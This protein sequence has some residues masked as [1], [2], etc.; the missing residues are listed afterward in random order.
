MLL[1]IMTAYAQTDNAG[2]KPFS[3]YTEYKGLVI[4]SG[5]I[6]NAD[7]G[8]N[9]EVHQAL[10]NVRAISINGCTNCYPKS[11]P[12]IITDLGIGNKIKI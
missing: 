3:N 12:Y 11:F 8:F 9:E 2:P 5:Q 7:A 1:F 6:G 4:L 10:N